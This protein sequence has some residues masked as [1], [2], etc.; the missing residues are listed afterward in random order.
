[1]R[2]NLIRLNR[3]KYPISAI[4]KLLNISRQGGC[5]NVGQG[6]KVDEYVEHVIQVFYDSHVIYGTGKIKAVLSREEICLSRRRI[7]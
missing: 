6:E 2:V 3:H 7:S 1:M 5:S 4:C